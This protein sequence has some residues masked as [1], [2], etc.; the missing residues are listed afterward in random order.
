MSY[1]KKYKSHL[2]AQGLITAPNYLAEFILLRHAENRGI[3]LPSRIWNKTL[4]SKSLQWKYWYG[5][6]HGEMKRALAL[7]KKFNLNHI[8]KALNTGE[9]KVILSL[10]NKKLSRLVKDVTI[11]EEKNEKYKEKVELNIVEP[12]TLPRSYTNK[13][14]KLGKLK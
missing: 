8:L 1:S 2:G 7:L 13:K 10:Q 14:S 11:Q 3:K 6:Y 9:G 5:L 12:T 4:Y